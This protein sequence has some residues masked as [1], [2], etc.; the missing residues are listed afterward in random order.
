[1]GLGGIS[2][3][4]VR[5]SHSVLVSKHR[6]T[7]HHLL[8]AVTIRGGSVEGLSSALAV[9]IEQQHSHPQEHI[10]KTKLV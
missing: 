5:P 7:F 10:S 4:R 1:M 2:S 9:L 3:S 8:I 6:L